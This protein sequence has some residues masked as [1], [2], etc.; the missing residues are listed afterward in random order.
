[1]QTSQFVGQ[2]IGPLLGG[3]AADAKGYSSV[4]F[5]SA[6]LKLISLITIIT[7]VHER[8]RRAAPAARPAP[9]TGERVR[10]LERLKSGALATIANRTTMVLVITLAA[11]SFALAVLSPVLSLYIQSL[12]GDVP[13][14]ATIAGSVMSVAAVTS[15]VSALVLG[16]M[17]DRIGQRKVLIACVAGAAAIHVPQAMVT[18]PNQLLVLRGIQGVFMG[19]IMPTANALLARATPP[20]RRGTV[21][22]LATAPAPR[23]GR[24]GPRWAPWPPAPGGWPAPFW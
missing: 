23:V 13:N 10:G 7:M 2:S 22:G 6:S 4:F 1:M 20:E 21:F 19:G 11:N 24:W 3:V 17:A 18:H 15:S 9:A 14:L 16:R 5:V 12:V 8:A